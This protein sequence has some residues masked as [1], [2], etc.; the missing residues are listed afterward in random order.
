LLRFGE[1]SV[2]VA[3]GSVMK[4]DKVGHYRT[5]NGQRAV[6]NVI[7]SGRA[8]GCIM[9][10]GGFVESAFWYC[11]DASHPTQSDLRI[12]SEWV[13]VKRPDDLRLIVSQTL[14]RLQGLQRYRM[15]S[16]D[17]SQAMVADSIDG[18]WLAADEML[19]AIEDLRRAMGDCTLD[20]ER[21]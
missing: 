11:G 4:I 6:I 20:E 7:F 10:A 5:S 1:W 14:E 3:E 15:E 2:L 19:A 13:A 8:F 21:K 9:D 12:V 16:D 17:K 18:E